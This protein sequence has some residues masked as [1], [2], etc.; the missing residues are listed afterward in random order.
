M[1]LSEKKQGARLVLL[2]VVVFSLQLV[3]GLQYSDYFETRY[4]R[5]DIDG[6]GIDEKVRRIE[7]PD[8]T[9]D[10]WVIDEDGSIYFSRFNE[11]GVL[12]GK[13]KTDPDGNH[14][15]WSDEKGEWLL[16]ENLNLIPDEEE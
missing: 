2:F 14:F 7:E 1:K 13:E 10:L 3:I 5:E 4:R 15:V 9:S 6:D 8:G 11:Q 16:D 12:L